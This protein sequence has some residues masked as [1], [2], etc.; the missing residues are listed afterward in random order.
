MSDMALAREILRQILWSAETIG[1]RFAPILS[2]DD[3]TTSDA[4]MEKLDAICMQLIALGESIKSLDRSTDGGLL[5]RYPAIEWKRVL[6]MRDV[7]SHHYFDLDAE[8]VY[9]VCTDHIGELAE[10]VRKMI[11]DLA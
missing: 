9:S 1:N 2:P 10:E 6:G 8:I 4:G 7:F 5:G 3:F 11:N